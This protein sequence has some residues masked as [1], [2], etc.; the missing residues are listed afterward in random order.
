MTIGAVEWRG[1]R[2]A[3]KL[4]TASNDRTIRIWNAYSGSELAV[5]HGHDDEVWE[6]VV[7]QRS[8]AGHRVA[9]SHNSDLGHRQRW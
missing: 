7:T 9:R 6:V 8:A 3:A 1:H 2:T 5:L 4:A